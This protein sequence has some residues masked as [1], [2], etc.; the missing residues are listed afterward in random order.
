MPVPPLGVAVIAAGVAPEQTLC[1]DATPTVGSASTTNVYVPVVVPDVH[2]VT[3][4]V[5]W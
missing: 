5:K 1:A 3:V 4:R 2:E